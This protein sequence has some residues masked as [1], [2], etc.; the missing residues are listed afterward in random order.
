MQACLQRIASLYKYTAHA[1]SEKKPQSGGIEL[2]HG[3]TKPEGA[4][5]VS[6][7][8]PQSGGIEL[9]H[10]FA[11]NSPKSLAC[12]PDCTSQKAST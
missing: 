1:V 12:F 8:K 6:E 7:K 9:V 5:A 11:N 4:H 10:R 2:E 3:W